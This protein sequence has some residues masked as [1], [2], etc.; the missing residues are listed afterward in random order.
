MKSTLSTLTKTKSLTLQLYNWGFI[1]LRKS[2]Q[3]E[4]FIKGTQYTGGWNFVVPDFNIL[5]YSLRSQRDKFVDPFTF[6]YLFLYVLVLLL[7]WG[8]ILS[9]LSVFI[10]FIPADV[11]KSNE[12][13]MFTYLNTFFRHFLPKLW[14][15]MTFY[16]L[17]SDLSV[18]IESMAFHYCFYKVRVWLLEAKNTI[19]IWILY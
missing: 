14:E 15:F 4:A 3:K 18:F 10:N 1:G 8:W 7:K 2:P 17:T 5:P 9:C 12:I 6:L 19:I 11:S 16:F 13:T